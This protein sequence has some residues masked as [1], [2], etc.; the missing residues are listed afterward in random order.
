MSNKCIYFQFSTYFIF[1]FFQ[2]WVLNSFWSTPHAQNPIWPLNMWLCIH[3]RVLFVHLS[4]RACVCVVKSAF[5][6]LAIVT[7]CTVFVIVRFWEYLSTSD[8]KVQD[9]KGQIN[10][11][12]FNVYY[13]N[14][15][16]QFRPQFKAASQWSKEGGLLVMLRKK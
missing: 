3:E 2:D 10:L 7:I 9:E 8:E 15:Y 5:V 4:G 13:I 6:F 12:F 1:V 11:L 14:I 16:H